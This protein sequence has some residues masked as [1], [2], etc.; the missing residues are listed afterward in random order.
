MESKY[1]ITAF[2]EIEQIEMG[3]DIARDLQ[4]VGNIFPSHEDAFKALGKIKIALFYGKKDMRIK[5]KTLVG[6]IDEKGKL[7]APLQL[8]GD[9]CNLNKGRSVIIHIEVQ[10]QEASEKLRNYVFGYVVPEMQR[11][12][13]D[14]GEDY[15]REQTFDY[16]KS[17]CPVFLDEE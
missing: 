16:L 10:P 4:R 15:T 12:L 6:R 7:I 3:N 2:G 9:F 17:L 8:L 11:I 5:R 13:H 14:N 1:F